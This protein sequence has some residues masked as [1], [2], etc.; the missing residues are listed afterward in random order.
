MAGRAR[1]LTFPIV[2]GSDVGERGP[3][4]NKDFVFVVSDSPYGLS[5]PL[6]LLNDRSHPSYANLKHDTQRQLYN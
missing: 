2:A 3:L 6:P 4:K 1:F 5:F